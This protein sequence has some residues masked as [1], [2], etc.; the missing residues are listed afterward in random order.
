MRRVEVH[1]RRP[2]L[3]LRSSRLLW[4]LF[5][6]DEETGVDLRSEVVRQPLWQKMSSF[7][8]CDCLESELDSSATRRC[9]LRGLS[10]RE[11]RI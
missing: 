1:Q 5:V 8:P 2:E 9:S 7:L 11:G 6:F 3:D 4:D 10:E